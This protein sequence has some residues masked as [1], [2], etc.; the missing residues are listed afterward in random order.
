MVTIIMV[1][2]TMD[3]AN[4]PPYGVIDGRYYYRPILL[5]RGLTKWHVSIII[6]VGM[7]AEDVRIL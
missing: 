5:Y 2:A 3:V 4:V 1:V 7:D 6:M